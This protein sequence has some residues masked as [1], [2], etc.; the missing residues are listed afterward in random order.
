MAAAV[1]Y[2]GRLSGRWFFV[3]G[4]YRRRFVDGGGR[5]N[6][7]ATLEQTVAA[8]E[9]GAGRT[10]ITLSR[11]DDVVAADA[12]AGAPVVEQLSMPKTDDAGMPSHSPR[13]RRSPSRKKRTP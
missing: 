7:Q 9:L 4:P 6:R 12:H 8:L 2:V 10:K 5:L 1:N 13:R 3:F 11:V